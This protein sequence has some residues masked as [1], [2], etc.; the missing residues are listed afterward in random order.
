VSLAGQIDLLASRIATEFNTIRGLIAAKEPTLPALGGVTTFLRGDRT[1][2]TLFSAT[3]PA[4]V[5]PTGAVGTA[6]TTARSDHSHGI[7][8][9]ALAVDLTSAQTVGGN[10]SFT[11][12]LLDSGGR[13]YSETNRP[14]SVVVRCAT[15]ANATLSG[16]L[17]IDGVVTAAGDLVLVKNQSASGNNGVYTVASGAW[18]RALGLTTAAALSGATVRVTTGTANGGTLWTSDLQS[19][20]TLGTTA[21]AWTRIADTT[22][23]A[24]LQ[25][26]LDTLT[27]RTDAVN[28]HIVA[29]ATD[30]TSG[31]TSTWTTIAMPTTDYAN[32]MTVASSIITVVRAGTYVVAGNFATDTASS[33]TGPRRTAII[34]TWT[35]TDLG[36]GNAANIQVARQEIP[37]VAAAWPAF[38]MTGIWTFAAGAK[39]RMALWQ[40]SGGTI[41][42]RNTLRP[43]DLALFRVV[44]A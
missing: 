3:T 16:V 13:I 30:Q 28:A 29:L 15:T 39:I 1:W 23:T 9:S 43:S 26:S 17:T 11:G 6:A 31:A 21:Q 7:G 42:I 20:A 41:I 4:A 36:A 44:G 24:A 12:T 10:K 37:W 35:G 18:T 5:T 38:S 14:G 27:T 19:T 22:D 40:N 33:G 32:G 34:E 8:I 25:S 2:A